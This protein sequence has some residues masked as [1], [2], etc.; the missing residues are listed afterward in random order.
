VVVLFRLILCLISSALRPPI[1]PLGEATVHMRVWPNDL[2]LNVHA[3][4]GRYQSF[5]DIGRIAL[6]FRLR[7]ARRV[8]V[9]RKWRPLVGGSMI[10]FRKSLLPFEKFAV[11]SRILCWDEKWFYFEHIIERMSGE[12]SAIGTV[13]G[14]LR[15]PEGNI[16]PAEMIALAGKPV[17]APPIPDYIVRWREAEKRA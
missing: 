1:D 9:A 2:D 13:R 3:N 10:T 8:F 15:G 11:R 6:V 4:S 12:V 14:L 16:P 5:M 17:E 7:L